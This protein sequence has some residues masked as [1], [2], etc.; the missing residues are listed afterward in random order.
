MVRTEKLGSFSSQYE[1]LPGMA[2]TRKGYPP[3]RSVATHVNNAG[4]RTIEY[5]SMKLG[6]MLAKVNLAPRRVCEVI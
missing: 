5:T 3:S 4:R 1:K 2:V 6:T